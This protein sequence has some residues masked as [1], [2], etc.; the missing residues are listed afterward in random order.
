ME[1][2]QGWALRLLI[3]FR[4]MI[5]YHLKKSLEYM[6][7]TAGG[8]LIN[9]PINYVFI[10]SCTNSRIEDF[11]VAASFVKGKKKPTM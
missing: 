11:R 3:I 5:Q 9:Q 2:I 8:S 6:N 7:F 10:G 4:Q 1:P